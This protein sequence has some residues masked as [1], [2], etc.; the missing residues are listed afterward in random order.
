MSFLQSG[1]PFDEAWVLEMENITRSGKGRPGPVPPAL[2][3]RGG[4]FG[5]PIIAKSK[6]SPLGNGHDRPEFRISQQ[7]RSRRS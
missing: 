6:P 5:N 4:T 2:T 7:D 3:I 1:G